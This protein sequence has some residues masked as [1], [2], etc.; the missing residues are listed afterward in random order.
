MDSFRPR[1]HN[2]HN[3]IMKESS[4]IINPQAAEANGPKC[5][6]DFGHSIAILRGNS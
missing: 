4:N 3:Q 5:E 1:L 2:P 6:K